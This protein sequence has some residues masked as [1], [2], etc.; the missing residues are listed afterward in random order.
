MI[1]F[2]WS[3]VKDVSADGLAFW[4]ADFT[5]VSVAEIHANAVD[6]FQLS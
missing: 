2:A 4:M 1:V 6:A 3:G 5:E